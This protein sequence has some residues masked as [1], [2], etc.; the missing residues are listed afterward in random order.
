VG[1]CGTFSSNCSGGKTIM[2]GR[3]LIAAITLAAAPLL[4][5]L[6]A[7]AFDEGK[8]PEIS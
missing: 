8:Y 1:N 7:Q 2:R 6:G 5:P 4:T 3:N